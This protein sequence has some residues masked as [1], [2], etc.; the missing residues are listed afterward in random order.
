MI[1]ILSILL[2]VLLY[3]IG[4]E[5]GIVSFLSLCFNLVI[6]SISMIALSW[7]LPAIPVTFLG[8]FFIAFATLFYQNGN[9]AKTIASFWSLM[10]V[11]ILLFG[12]TYHMGTSYH[13]QGIN[14]IIQREDEV[15]GLS[16]NLKVNMWQIA[17]S[18]IIIGLMGAAM[19]ASVAVSSAVYE[20]YKNNRTLQIGDLFISGMHVGKDILG[21]TVN[22]LYFACL[23]ESLSLFL[24]FKNNQ[25]SFFALLNSKALFQEVSMISISCISCS[26]IIP[27]TAFS[28]SYILTHPDRLKRFLEEDPLFSEF[29]KTNPEVFSTEK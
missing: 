16:L 22:T 15:L 24:L 19:D 17:F 26:L 6:L 4:G 29:E 10:F 21:A 27:I 12:L 8:C 13:M 18:M 20:V 3:F 14:E 9:N 5:R 25:Y 1:Q 11:L 23:G 2:I 28:V 7:G